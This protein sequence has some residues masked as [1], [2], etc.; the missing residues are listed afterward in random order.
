MMRGGIL[1]LI[2][3]VAVAVAAVLVVWLVRVPEMY[4]VE[5]NGEV[6]FTPDEAE[7]TASIYAENAVSLDAAKEAAGTMRQI[8]ASLK[9]VEIAEGDIRTA[10]VRSGLLDNERQKPGEA[11]VYYAEQTVSINVKDI[12]RIGK[13]LDSIARAGSNYWL[14]TYKSSKDEDLSAAARAAA[15]ANAVAT[16]DAYA[17]EGK[18][19]RGRVLKIQDGDVTFPS[20]DY[21]GR[22]YRTGRAGYESVEKVTVTGTRIKE[23]P[24]ETTFDV[25]PPK[26]RAVKASTHVLF[27]IE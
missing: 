5:G 12:R 11:R 6:R 4:T 22:E 27:A 24:I 15:L 21:G 1:A 13:I 20:V 25:P 3:V 14:V 2:G 8:L 23:L 26:E 17:R 18:F 7:I 9:G 10:D 19:K 16:A